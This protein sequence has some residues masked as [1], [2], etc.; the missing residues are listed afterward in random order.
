[1]KQ[2]RSLLNKLLLS[3]IVCESTEEV[4]LPTVSIRTKIASKISISDLK[5]I[6]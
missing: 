1:M 6:D 4:K 2:R 5:T 3:T